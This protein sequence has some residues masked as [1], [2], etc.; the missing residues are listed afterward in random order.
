M[1]RRLERGDTIVEV[2]FAFALF[3]IAAV[4]SMQILSKGIAATQRNLETT[5]VRQQIDSQAEMIRYIRDGNA[6]SLR[7]T[8]G[9][10][11]APSALVNAPTSLS[12]SC[13][14][15]TTNAFYI[16][17][18]VSS[19]NPENTTFS[20]VGLTNQ[21]AMLDDS[22]RGNYTYAQMAYDGPS[23]SGSK[24]IWIEAVRAQSASIVT[25]PQAYDFY[26]HAC[27]DSVGINTPMTAG[28]IV[29]VYE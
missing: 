19:T 7:Q 26:I 17:T 11:V 23:I 6:G 9:A 10:L 21:T 28:T 1:K 16:R 18:S 27:W 24:G 22:R 25:G 2:T 20:R 5:L 29:R 3:A 13:R 12:D 4:A 14:I 8:W 15:R